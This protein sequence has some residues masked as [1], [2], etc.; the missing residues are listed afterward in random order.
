MN[1]SER[2]RSNIR[3]QTPPQPPFALQGDGCGTH[4]YCIGAHAC[5]M[6]HKLQHFN[7]IK[8]RAAVGAKCPIP[9]MVTRCPKPAARSLFPYDPMRRQPSNLACCFGERV[10]FGR[11]FPGEVRFF[12]T[13]VAMTC[14]FKVD[15]TQQVEPVDNARRRQ[16]ECVA[17]G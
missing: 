3:A 1:R 17:D 7:V 5:R 4:H 16:V 2:D 8:H 10:G 15:R 12:A 14:G 13:E 11:C 6:N 9:C